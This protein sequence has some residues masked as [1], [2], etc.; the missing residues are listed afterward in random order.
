M[1]N[2]IETLF[3]LLLMLGMGNIVQWLS[4]MEIYSFGG[5]HRA[6]GTS[7]FQFMWENFLLQT[8]FAEEEACV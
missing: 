4:G 6:D 7:L 5:E 8:F 1:S 2:L 3:G